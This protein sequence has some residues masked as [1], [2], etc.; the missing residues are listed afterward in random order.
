MGATYRVWLYLSFAVRNPVGGMA[1]ELRD[2]HSER[3]ATS[4]RSHGTGSQVRFSIES[5][6]V[7]SCASA[8]IGVLVVDGA[9]CGGRCCDD[10]GRSRIG[11]AISPVPTVTVCL[12]LCYFN[13]LLFQPSADQRLGFRCATEMNIW[14]IMVILRQSTVGE[15]GLEIAGGNHNDT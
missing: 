15:V 5:N 3:M 13:H 14:E 11:S 12:D 4:Y 9:I 8:L 7:V 6:S 10:R 2:L 1:C